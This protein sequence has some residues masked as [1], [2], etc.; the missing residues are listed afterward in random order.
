MSRGKSTQG[1]AIGQIV[2]PRVRAWASQQGF[3]LA[4]VP[5][6]PQLSA[7]LNQFVGHMPNKML[8]SL[9]ESGGLYE[10]TGRSSGL[11]KM[12]HQQLNEF[13]IDEG[14]GEQNITTDGGDINPWNKELWEDKNLDERNEI[15]AGL[16]PKERDALS[17]QEGAWEPTSTTAS[18]PNTAAD[19]LKIA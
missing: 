4:N 13:W 9:V 8:D 6:I 3:S 5:G 1:L 15:I 18:A 14:F 11:S 16:S 10:L 17:S 12:N 2:E 19:E 7:T